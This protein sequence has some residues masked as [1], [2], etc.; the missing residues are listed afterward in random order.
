MEEKN[1]KEK[2]VKEMNNVYVNIFKEKVRNDEEK[3]RQL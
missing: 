2:F 1:M 3:E